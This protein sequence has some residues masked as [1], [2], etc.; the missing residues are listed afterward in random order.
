MLKMN[1]REIVI[2]IT[3]NC[4]SRCIMCNIWKKENKKEFDNRLLSQLFRSLKNINITGGEPFLRRDIP[5]VVEKIK[6]ICPDSRIV[7]TTNGI[8]TEL[9][10]KDMREILKIEPKV[11][12]RVSL[13]GLGDIHD[14]VRGLP[15][16]YNNVIRTVK[17][18]KEIGVKDLGIHITLINANIAQLD[19]VYNLASAKKVKFNCYIAHNSDFYF[20]KENEEIAD[21]PLLHIYL[22]QI[23]GSELKTFD[24]YRLFKTYY[25]KGIWDYV[26][27]IP[28][29]YR[30]HAGSLFC[31]IDTQGDVYPCIMLEEKMGSLKE[32]SLLEVL[33]TKQADAVREKVKTCNKNCWLICTSAPEI[34]NWPYRALLWV[35]KSKVKAH[36]GFKNYL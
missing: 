13:D 6:N 17:L 18:L 3:D 11:A 25:Y 16:A 21:K 4:N 24:L 23:I 31:Y 9:I 29:E 27:R 28:R 32:R 14:R 8:L 2:S 15:G 7:I 5:E 26:N 35:L 36:L 22:N 12:L 34:K 20:G 10:L 30:C 33:R 19:N 1:L